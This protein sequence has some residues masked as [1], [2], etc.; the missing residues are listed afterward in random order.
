MIGVGMDGGTMPFNPNWDYD[1]KTGVSRKPKPRIG[2]ELSQV[3]AVAASSPMY[4][5]YECEGSSNPDVMYMKSGGMTVKVE[6]MAQ[7]SE[8]DFQFTVIKPKK[9]KWSQGCDSIDV[10]IDELLYDLN[11]F[12]DEMENG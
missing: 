2:D 7:G 4:E 3:A 10:R 1:K 12:V 6:Y 8:F 11:D 5:H 9:W